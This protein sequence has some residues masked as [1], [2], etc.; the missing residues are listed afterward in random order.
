MRMDRICHFRRTTS[1]SLPLL[2]L[3]ALLAPAPAW[4]E[5][6]LGSRESAQLTI[7]HLADVYSISP[8]DGGK[9]GGLARVATIKKQLAT[10]KRNVIVTLAGDFLSPSVASGI[11]RG[12]QMVESLNVMELDIATLGNHEFDFGSE[13]L[14]Q[15]MDQADWD[16]VVT[17]VLDAATGQPMGGAAPY[18]VREYGDLKV[19]FL[20]LC[21]AGAEINP[22]NTEGLDFLDPFEA[23][24]GVLEEL[25]REEVDLVIALTHLDYADDVRLA[26]RFPR[27]DLVLGGHEHFPITSQVGG[28]LITKPGSDARFIS[29][30]DVSRPHSEAAIEKHFE[31]VAVSEDIE[32]DPATATVVADWEAQID[33]QLDVIVGSTSQPLDA[34]AESVRSG[35]SNLGNLMADAMRRATGAEIAIING[36]SIRSNRIYPAGE[37]SRRD[38]L[39]IHPF[40]GVVCEVEVPGSVVLRALEHGVSRLGESVG[41]FPQ[42]SGLRFSVDPD[43]PAGNRVQDVFV[44]E[45]AL[46]AERLYRVAVGDYMLDGGD[47]YSMFADARVLVDGEEGPLLV[48]AL[49]ETVETQ[50]QVGPEIEGR[51]V[52]A[53]QVAE[54]RP[55]RPVILDTDMGIDSVMGMLYLLESPE[56]DLRAI[57]VVH[58]IADLEAGAQNALRILEL[59]GNA[60][61]PVATGSGAPLEG[62]REFPSFWKTQ[63]NTL[64]GAR[65]PA[66]TAERQEDGVEL[67]LSTLN[68]SPEPVTIVAMGPLTNVALAFEQDPDVVSKVDEL[69]VMGGALDVLGNVGNPFVGIDNQ[70]A[71]WNFYLDPQAAEMVLA[72]GVRIR[73]LPLDSTRTLPVTREFVDQVRE[74][75]RDQT[76]DLLLSLLLAVEDGIDAGWY[77]FWDVLAAVATARP[78]VLACR[79]EQIRVET[80]DGPRLGEIIRD[81]EGVE[82]CVA[83]EI[84][85]QAFE[86]DLLQAILD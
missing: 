27:I 8:V 69:I 49:A 45:E 85:R 62:Q 4:S 6:A 16:W 58:G 24:G 38:I 64:G 63:A 37:L 80:A 66:A 61:I 9:A 34:V 52:F 5:E 25:E 75:P 50:G 59:T 79:T 19:G 81:P 31:L 13:V 11:F 15:R 14:R 67:I 51:I 73:L 76:S 18:L 56:I 26:Q 20:G 29:R 41:R 46:D 71:E 33:E 28:T 22:R 40:G 1:G 77:Y 82:V 53:S 86:D 57:T 60:R 21:L 7:L 12:I 39:A 17:N 83:E 2:A 72:S 78:D 35:E 68:G 74:R 32:D 23:A 3:L 65:L 10:E 30:I 54:Q 70:T 42:V 84:N 55:K 44:G 48:S 43:K 36:G 47:G